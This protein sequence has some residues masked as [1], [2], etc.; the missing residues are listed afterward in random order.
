MLINSKTKS[1]LS[2]DK[3]LILIFSM[4]IFNSSSSENDYNQSPR[5]TIKKSLK[6]GN[7]CYYEAEHSYSNQRSQTNYLAELLKDEN[8]KSN[9]PI[10]STILADTVV[11]FDT[12]VQINRVLVKKLLQGKDSSFGNYDITDF[13]APSRLLTFSLFDKMLLTRNYDK[14][15]IFEA[16]WSYTPEN[17]TLIS[18]KVLDKSSGVTVD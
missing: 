8:C 5:E 3:F 7:W 17:I 9:K 18:Y 6:I 11:D 2:F 13:I 16:K 1:C 10:N 14:E 15:D 4:A 12:F